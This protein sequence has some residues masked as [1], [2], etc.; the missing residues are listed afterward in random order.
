MKECQTLKTN[1]DRTLRHY[2]ERCH[3]LLEANEKYRSLVE[4]QSLE[5]RENLSKELEQL[6]EE[7]QK[8]HKQVEVGRR[9]LVDSQSGLISHFPLI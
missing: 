3:A 6:K 2:T 8:L 9:S 4:E 1:E 5:T 7:N